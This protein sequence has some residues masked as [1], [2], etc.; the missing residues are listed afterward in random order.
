MDTVRNKKDDAVRKVTPNML[1][2]SPGT[3]TLSSWLCAVPGDWHAMAHAFN[4]LDIFDTWVRTPA[5]IKYL[6]DMTK[7]SQN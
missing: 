5:A 1:T 3:T 7:R 6:S 4:A 2:T